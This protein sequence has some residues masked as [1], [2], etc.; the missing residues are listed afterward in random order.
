L[1]VAGHF[2]HQGAPRD[3]FRLV[4]GLCRIVAGAQ[5]QVDRAGDD[6]QRDRDEYAAQA[7]EP[8]VLRATRE[9]LL[10]LC[11]RLDGVLRVV[12]DGSLLS[13]A[14]SADVQPPPSAL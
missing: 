6:E 7:G 10:Q 8:A 5:V 3:G 11:R 9:D 13:P 2:D 1:P 4:A 12:H 14:V